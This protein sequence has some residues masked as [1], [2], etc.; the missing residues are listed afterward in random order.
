[1]NERSLKRKIAKETLKFA[2]FLAKLGPGAV[3]VAVLNPDIPKED[4]HVYTL[5]FGKEEENKR[6]LEN[7]LRDK[8]SDGKTLEVQDEK[9]PEPKSEGKE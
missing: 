2:N 6:T 7:V 9:E 8:L 3:I 1:M 5:V 4:D